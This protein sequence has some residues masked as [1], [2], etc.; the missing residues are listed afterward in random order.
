[1]IVSQTLLTVVGIF[2]GKIIAQKISE[3]KLT[4]IA[5][6]SFIL[7]GLIASY[8]FVIKDLYPY[9]YGENIGQTIFKRLSTKA[10]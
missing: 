7:F 10:Q 5:G 6:A 4:L 8:F 9:L 3:K 1:V 2:S